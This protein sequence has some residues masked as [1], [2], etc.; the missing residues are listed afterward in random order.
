MARKAQGGCGDLLSWTRSGLEL[1]WCRATAETQKHSVVGSLHGQGSCG[2]LVTF[3]WEPF[4]LHCGG[5]AL[6]S[7]RGLHCLCLSFGI[8]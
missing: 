2:D 4:V 6:R 3:C 1:L 5:D 7:L 8:A